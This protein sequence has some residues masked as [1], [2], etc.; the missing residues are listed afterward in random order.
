MTKKLKRTSSKTI[1]LLY[2]LFYDVHRLFEKEGISYWMIGGTALGAVRH[3]GIIPWDDDIDIGADKRDK[4]RIWE[5]KSI[6]KKCGYGITRVWLG[7]KIFYLDIPFTKRH[8]YSFPNIDIFFYQQSKY[9][10]IPDRQSVRDMWPK[11]YFY[12]E[13]LYPLKKY[14]F[15]SFYAWG[16]YNCKEYFNRSYGKRW[17]IEA[18]RDYDHEK[19]EV[20]EK[21]LVKLNQSDRNPALPTNVKKRSCI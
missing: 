4:K 15:G 7:Y 11:E 9:K 3:N 21:I 1:R 14:N 2:Q 20:V 10:I 16:P 13:E 17:N 6:L 8:K 5:L 19:E 12:T 18:Y